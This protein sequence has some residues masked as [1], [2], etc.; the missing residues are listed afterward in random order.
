MIT[1]IKRIALLFTPVI[2]LFG[3]KKKVNDYYAPPANLEPTGL[4]A[5]AG[6]RKIYPVPIFIDKA[7]YKQTLN[8][9]RL[10]DCFCS[11]GF[12]F[13]SRC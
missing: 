6:K 3:C 8:T 2:T 5:T 12:R 1:C 11:I 10:L 7:G 13:S 4:P 9:C